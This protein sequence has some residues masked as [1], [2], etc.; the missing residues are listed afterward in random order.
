MARHQRMPTL[1]AGYTYAVVP[2]LPKQFACNEEESIYSSLGILYRKVGRLDDSITVLEKQLEL[3]P[4]YHWAHFNLAKSYLLKGNAEQ[5]LEEIKENPSNEYRQVG[6]VMVYS[7]LGRE[8]EARSAQEYLISEYGEH[9]PT[10]VAETFSWRRENDQAF[11]WLEKAYTQKDYG[12][13]YLLANSVFENLRE[14]P[15]WEELLQKLDL[16]EHW[17][18]MLPEYGGPIKTMD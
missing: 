7:T 8:A 13:A 6:L 1:E 12:L 16:F 10:W 3:R 11:E 15:R 17:Q 9:N 18:K 4:N 14:D 2:C 5:A